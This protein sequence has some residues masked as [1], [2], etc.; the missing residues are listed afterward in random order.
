MNVENVLLI[1]VDSL[2]AQNVGLYNG[3]HDTTPYLDTLGADN[4]VFNNTIC[5]QG[6]SWFSYTTM[7]RGDHVF[8]LPLTDPIE[9]YDRIHEDPQYQRAYRNTPIDQT[10]PGVLFEEGI[11]TSAIVSGGMLDSSWGW[12]Q[13]FE[14]YD[15]D[16]TTDLQKRVVSTKWGTFGYQ[17]AQKYLPR[18]IEPIGKRPAEKTSELARDELDQLNDGSSPWFLFVQFNDTHTPLTP[19]NR[20]PDD[21]HLYDQEVRRA[22]DGIKRVVEKLDELEIKDETLV[23]ITADHGE[24]LGERGMPYGHGYNV[25]EESVNVPLILSNPNLERCRLTDGVARI[26]DIA[27]TVLD[28]LSAPIPE[29]FTAQSLLEP[30][31]DNGEMPKDAL[32]FVSGKWMIEAQTGESMDQ[33]D[34]GPVIALRTSEEKFVKAPAQRDCTWYFDL[35][36]DPRETTNRSAEAPAEL[37]ERL[38]QR[39]EDWEGRAPSVPAGETWN[40]STRME[41]QLRDLGYM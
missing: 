20:A 30:A 14:S 24:S 15:D 13:G 1:V 41:A 32:T 5:P 38:N 27:P 16:I 9:Y 4:V 17:A 8:S 3:S 34:A 12:D 23:I 35:T 33:R 21:W 22:D 2:R 28:E 40:A 39:V 37:K 36:T 11:A 6:N 18:A 25:Y 26:K 7:F 31:A 10:T 29:T 19:Y